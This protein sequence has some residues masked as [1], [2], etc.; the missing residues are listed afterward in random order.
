MFA[1][2]CDIEKCSIHDKL[3]YREKHPQNT[4]GQ[5]YLKI[6]KRGIIINWGSCKIISP[7][8]H[9]LPVWLV[10]KGNTN[11]WPIEAAA[12]KVPQ[13]KVLQKFCKSHRITIVLEFFN[14]VTGVRPATF[15]K[16]RLQHTSSPVN[17]AK[18]FKNTF[19]TEHL[20]ATPC[21]PT[22]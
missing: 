17:F 2:K 6:G 16:K 10:T 11:F 13:K 14:K 20:R 15:L 4:E 18:M 9:Y 3:K 5:L 21:G 8:K 7:K 19:F 12:G 22:K 1:L